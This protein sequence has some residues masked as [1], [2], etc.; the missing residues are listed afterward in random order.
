MET[1]LVNKKSVGFT[2]V[3]AF[4]IDWRKWDETIVLDLSGLVFRTQS[5]QSKSEKIVPYLKQ[6]MANIVLTEKAYMIYEY[7]YIQWMTAEKHE[8]L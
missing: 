3:K 4:F 8:Y 2:K 6:N 7:I 1:S 5:S